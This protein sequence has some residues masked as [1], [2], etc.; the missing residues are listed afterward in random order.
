MKNDVSFLFYHL[1]N[2]FL[3]F[4]LFDVGILSIENQCFTIKLFQ[5]L[6]HEQVTFLS[7]P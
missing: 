5:V 2:N 6:I 3:V 1:F 7:M 4:K